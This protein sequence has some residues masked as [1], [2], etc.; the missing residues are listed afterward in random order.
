[1]DKNLYVDN[2]IKIF[3]FEIRFRIDSSII[4][5]DDSTTTGAQ[6]TNSRKLVDIYCL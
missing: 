4:I 6:I 2:Y 3:V 1:M 5:A